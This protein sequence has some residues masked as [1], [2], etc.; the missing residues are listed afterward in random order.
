LRNQQRAS[1]EQQQDAND[2]E[3]LP[4]Y[5][6]DRRIRHVSASSVYPEQHPAA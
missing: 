3:C 2:A 1:R 5:H 4:K 6:L